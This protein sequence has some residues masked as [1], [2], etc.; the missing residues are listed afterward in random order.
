MQQEVIYHSEFYNK[1]NDTE[2]WIRLTDGCYRD[3]WNCYCPK[4]KVS[5]TL[6]P[7]ERNKV[8]FLDMNFLY[9][10]P[11]PLIVI[12]RLGKYKVNNRVVYYDFQCGV[13]FTLLTREIA[14]A[15][16]KSRFGRF[17]NKRNYC[18]GLRVA[19]D[20][21]FNEKDIFERKMQMLY[22]VGYRRI[23][24]FMLVNGMI[25]FDECVSKLKILKDLRLEICDCWYDNQKRGSVK[26]I[27]WTQEQCD[28]FGKLC[29]AHNVAITQRQYA[30]MDYLYAFIPSKNE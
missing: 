12:E 8:V 17:N 10:H 9:A 11:A 25:P 2:Q 26:A 27:Y 7:I 23:Q 15:L 5:Y 21:G 19:W 4:Y 28:L 6:P 30:A 29:R 1:L 3:C 18:N 22:K 13:D 14:I 16:K 24:V 20:R